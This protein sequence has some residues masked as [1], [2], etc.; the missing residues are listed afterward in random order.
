MIPRVPGYAQEDRARMNQLVRVLLLPLALAAAA[1]VT[2]NV[3]FPAAAAE[4]AAER[5]VKEVYGRGG[6]APAGEQ[7]PAPAGEPSSALEPRAAE[8]LAARV[9]GFVIADARAQEADIDIST[10][11][12]N[13]LKAAMRA[14]HEQ[15]RPYYASGAIGMAANGLLVVRDPAAVALRERNA[16]NQLVA[17]ENRDRNRLYAEVARANGHPEWEPRIREIFARQWVANAPGGW[18]YQD[19][20]GWT[21]K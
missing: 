16:V 5:F 9:A 18:W 15:L 6:Q 10:P 13:A 7:T 14:R 17:E 8:R 19:A 1:C 21:Q 20:T 3:Y 12:I 2:V 4:N 11:A